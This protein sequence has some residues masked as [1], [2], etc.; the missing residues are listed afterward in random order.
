[1]KRDPNIRIIKTA[2]Q[3]LDLQKSSKTRNGSFFCTETK[4]WVVSSGSQQIDWCFGKGVPI[5]SLILVDQEA[6]NNYYSHILYSFASEGAQVGHRIVWVSPKTY[7]KDFFIQSSD[8]LEEKERVEKIPSIDPRLRI[9]WRYQSLKITED[10]LTKNIPPNHPSEPLN[11]MKQILTGNTYEKINSASD[12]YICMNF[13]VLLENI[14]RLTLEGFGSYGWFDCEN[15]FLTSKFLYSLKNAVKNSPV[16]CFISV[17]S[18]IV[19]QNVMCSL[20]D[21]VDAHIKLVS[22]SSNYTNN[23]DFDGFLEYRDYSHINSKIFDCPRLFDDLV[24]KIRRNRLHIQK[25]SLSSVE[26]NQQPD[27]FLS[28]TSQNSQIIDSF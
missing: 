21:I 5:G 28:C 11:K 9:A 19:H 10:T 4:R 14:L 24:F 26:S 3:Q 6:E 16:I 7:E 2:K 25:L 8:K 22:S 18:Y 1:M 17:P 23:K 15:I 20:I 13:V 12:C 27:D